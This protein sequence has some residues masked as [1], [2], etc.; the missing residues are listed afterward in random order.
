MQNSIQNAVNGFVWTHL[1][2]PTTA[3]SSTEYSRVVS[4]ILQLFSKHFGLSRPCNKPNGIREGSLQAIAIQS[5][6]PAS[7]CRRRAV[8]VGQGVGPQ[9]PPVEKLIPA[10]RPTK[11]ES[12]ADS[13]VLQHLALIEAPTKRAR[14]FL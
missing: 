9:M 3:A 1:E 11:L 4:S 14:L 8:A 2:L 10:P 13:H 7:V 5:R 12:S 6:G